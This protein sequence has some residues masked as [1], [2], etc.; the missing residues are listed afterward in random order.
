MGLAVTCV[1]SAQTAPQGLR[2]PAADSASLTNTGIPAFPFIDSPL[3]NLFILTN[4]FSVHKKKR[5]PPRAPFWNN[6]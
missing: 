3:A 1:S 6:D 5:G 4:A 2:S